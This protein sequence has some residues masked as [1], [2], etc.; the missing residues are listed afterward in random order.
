MERIK[1]R[2]FL[3]SN[4]I[5][6]GLISVN[7]APRL[8]LDLLCL[9]LPMLQ[10]LTG[11]FNLMETE[12]NIAKKMPA[13]LPV[14]NHYLPRLKLEII[15]VPSPQELDVFRGTGEDKDVPVLASA[16]KGRA[17]FFI[18]GD[19]NLLALISRGGVFPVKS[20]SPAEFLDKVL[21]DILVGETRRREADK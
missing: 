10:G 7:G 12:R 14:F 17:D 3:D 13:A 16:T 11:R 21:P 6:S 1:H 19:K 20:F 5:L 18:T 2:I 9:D 4:V 8:I 15:P